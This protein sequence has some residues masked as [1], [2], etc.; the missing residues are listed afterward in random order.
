MNHGGWN[1]ADICEYDA[2]CSPRGTIVLIRSVVEGISYIVPSGV[3]S[4]WSR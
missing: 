4:K 2:S 1:G 3:S